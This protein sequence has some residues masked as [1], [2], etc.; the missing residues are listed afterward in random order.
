V[1][2]S[3]KLGDKIDEKQAQAYFD[4]DVSTMESKV[5]DVLTSNGGH[6]FSQGEFNALVD[7]S[8]NGGPAVLS[9]TASPNLMKEMNAGDYQGMSEQLRYTKTANGASMPGLQTRSDDRKA[10]FLGGDPE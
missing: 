10:I 6:Q 4:K 7:L 1:D 5:G 2:D 9:T 8:F 3:L